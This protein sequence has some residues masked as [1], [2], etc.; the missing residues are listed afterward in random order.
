MPFQLLNIKCEAFLFAGTSILYRN[1]VCRVRFTH[2]GA[3]PDV[4][5]RI[6]AFTGEDALVYMFYFH[7]FRSIL[8]SKVCS[9]DQ[10]GDRQALE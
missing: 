8:C 6:W 1:V 7:V 5:D 9:D 4:S 2:P 10:A 3:F